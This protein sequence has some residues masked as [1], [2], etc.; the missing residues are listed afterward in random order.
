MWQYETR[1]KQAA[2]AKEKGGKRAQ[3][4]VRDDEKETRRGGRGG[5]I[6]EYTT[7]SGEAKKKR[8]RTRWMDER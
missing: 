3:R 8:Q 1:R 7:K 6:E 2:K 5:Q 4:C